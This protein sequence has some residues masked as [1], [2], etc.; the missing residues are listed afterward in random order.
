MPKLA[1]LPTHITANYR[2]GLEESLREEIR[3]LNTAIEQGGVKPVLLASLLRFGMICSHLPDKINPPV[4]I[5][6]SIVGRWEKEGH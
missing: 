3:F 6:C 2:E 1:R 4:C 5:G